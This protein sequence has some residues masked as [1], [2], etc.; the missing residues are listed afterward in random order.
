MKR[1]GLLGLVAGLPI[2]GRCADP[3]PPSFQLVP[4]LRPGQ[5][6]RF[7]FERK[8]LRDDVVMQWY[9]APLH[10]RVLDSSADVAL[11][12]WAEGEQTIVDAHPQYRPL[13]ALG[14]AAARDVPL[15]ILVEASGRI[16]ALANPAE[17]RARC[18]SVVEATAALWRASAST[19]PLADALLPGLRAAYRTDA[20]VGASALRE[21]T[22]L[23]GAMGRRFG[24][25][26]PVE[27]RARLGHPTGGEPLEAIARFA[28]R[29]VQP[30]RKRAELG[31][32]L[33]SDP[34][35]TD[36]AARQAAGQAVDIAS[37]IAGKKDEDMAAALAAMPPVTLEERGD[38][39]VDTGTAWPLQVVHTRTVR[40]GARTQ[41]DRASFSR[42]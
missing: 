28:I 32:L 25:G 18:L 27:F 6:W 21:A 24:A 19:A 39:V 22:I 31:W 37:A 42:A 20:M 1:R 2:F 11:L 7:A 34:L 12:E 29:A 23:L 16:R 38:F 3:G 4:D 41:V 9:R 14:L 36:A 10:V 35:A 5:D 15:Q 30:R 33:V 8:V 17:V 26:E 40:A 13:M